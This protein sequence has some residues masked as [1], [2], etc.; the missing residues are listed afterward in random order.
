ME[1]TGG[2]FSRTGMS[3]ALAVFVL[4]GSLVWEG[5]SLITQKNG[6]LSVVAAA[7]SQGSAAQ[8]TDTN[9]LTENDAAGFGPLSSSHA[10]SSIADIGPNVMGQLAANYFAA[11]QSGSYS[12]QTGAQ[13]AGTMAP[14]VKA[15][16]PSKTYSLT[17]VHTTSDLSYARMLT[18]R[19]DLQVAL[20]PLLKNTE[21]EINIIGRYADTRNPAELVTLRSVAANYT[22]AAS[23]TAAVTVPQDATSYQIAILN[24]MEKFAA[25][26][27]AIADNAQDPIT[28]VALLRAYNQAEQDMFTSFNALAQYYVQKPKQ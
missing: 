23:N 22:L 18:Y 4:L 20:Q 12:P 9:P 7:A 28:S 16:V 17:D 8:S 13:I 25:T 11:Q 21:P 24:A 1:R 19:G 14:Y 6:D 15:T 27:N 10:T 3:A 26:L 2:T 5:V